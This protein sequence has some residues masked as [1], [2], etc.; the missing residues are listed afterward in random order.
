MVTLEGVASRVS[1]PAVAYLVQRDLEEFAGLPH[2]HVDRTEV[3]R[4]CINPVFSKLFTVDFYFEEV[5]R[6]R[7]EVHDISSNHNGLKEADFLGGMECTL[8]QIVSQRKL[9]KSLLKHGNTAGKSSITVIAEELSGNDDYVELSFSARKLDDKDFFSKSD[10]FLE[11]FRVNDDATQQLVHRTEV[12]MNNLNPAWKTFKVSVNSLCSGDQDRRLKETGRCGA[13]GAIP[14]SRQDGGSSFA[15]QVPDSSPAMPCGKPSYG[16]IQSMLISVKD[17]EKHL[18]VLEQNI[19]TFGSGDLSSVWDP[20]IKPKQVKLQWQDGKVTEGSNLCF[21]YILGGAHVD[22]HYVE[23]CI[24]WDWDSN[25]KHDFIGEFS[26][27]FKEMRG[28]MEGRQV[29]WECI[30]PKYKAKKKN[31]KN[32]GIVILNQ[33]K[34]A[35]DFT[36]SNGDPRN[37]CS[38]HYIHPYQPNEYLKA[39]VAVGEICQDYDRNAM[40]PPTAYA[41]QDN[42]AALMGSV[43]FGDK[44]FPAFGFGARIPPEYKVSHDFAINFNEDNP[45]CAGI[46]GVVEAYQ[47]CLPKLQLY[48]PTNIAPIIQKVA[49]SASE[50]TNTKE[51]SQYFILLILTDG[52]I[53]DMADTREAIVHASHLPMSVII[54]GVGNADFSDMQ[55]LDGDDGILRSPKGEP[56]LRDIVQFVPFRNFK[57]ASPAALA[58]SVLA[59]VP[60]QVVDY[61]NGKG[62]KPKCVS[63][64]QLC[65]RGRHTHSATWWHEHLSEENVEFMKQITTE[66]YKAQTA[67]K[68]CPLKDEPWPLNEWTPDSIRVGVVAVKLGMMPI[69]TKSGKKHAVTLLK[70]AESALQIFK[71]AGVPRKQKVATFNVTDDALIKPGTPL[72][73][74]HFRPGQFVDVTA[75]TIGKGFQGVMKRWGFK[76]Q[77]AS[78]GQTKTHRRPGAIST[79]KASKVYPGKKM[80]GKMGNIYRTTYGLKVWRINTKHDI[81]YVNGAVPGHTSCL[82]KVR[83]SKLPTC[84]EY[85]KNPPFPTFFADG[86]EELPEDLFDEEIFQFTDPSLTYT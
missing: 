48:G 39:L 46:Q 49:K 81:I 20:C 86:D 45:E 38:L 9:S 51:A 12:V 35:I 53:T 43:I 57:H 26:S 34:V 79:N 33:C 32:S 5:Q 36:A 31:Y 68:L 29:Q 13:Q 30:N 25:G 14:G 62:I 52:V 24:V 2:W 42:Q 4:T 7:F 23:E 76:G 63:E 18:Q 85:N 56:V 58:K 55:M 21:K 78:H 82:V 16:G 22:K 47:S 71:E 84:K 28:A 6:L 40:V 11:I 66:E 50:E 27:T 69:W 1:A 70:K 19:V 59:E 3:I 64:E 80:P 10:P 65:L 44:M 60:N 37:S 41:R 67:S 83:D 77:P 73:A 17:A 8:G 72:Y 61:Y 75:K 74:A 15:V 54:V